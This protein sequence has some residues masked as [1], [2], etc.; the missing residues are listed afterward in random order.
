MHW[1]HETVTLNHE[2]SLPLRMINVVS[3]MLPDIYRAAVSYTV[4]RITIN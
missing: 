2:T 1:K 4:L 3:I